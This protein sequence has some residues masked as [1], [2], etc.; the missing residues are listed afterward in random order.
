[1]G[2]GLGWDHRPLQPAGPPARHPLR[3]Y[4]QPYGALPSASQTWL[5]CPLGTARQGRW[6]QPG[7][8]LCPAH[9]DLVT[10]GDPELLDSHLPPSPV[11]S[12]LPS[13][14]PTLFWGSLN[15]FFRCFFKHSVFS[16]PPLSL[17]GQPWD[18]AWYLRNS[19]TGVLRWRPLPLLVSA[20]DGFWVLGGPGSLFPALSWSTGEEGPC[21][22]GR[23]FGPA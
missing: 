15:L 9:R 22:C 5:K 1:M 14:S 4:R 10:P 3:L 20:G 11:T 18:S 21:R 7:Q 12:S 19:Y 13:P 8:G 16:Q 2:L 23:L 6:V 17:Q